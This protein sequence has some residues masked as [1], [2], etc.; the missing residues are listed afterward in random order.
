[1]LDAGINPAN[2]CNYLRRT[3]KYESLRRGKDRDQQIELLEAKAFL[4]LLNR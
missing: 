4:L 1:M 2:F 3:I